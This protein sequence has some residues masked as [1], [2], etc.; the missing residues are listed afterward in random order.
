MSNGWQVPWLPR[1]MTK[2]V[3]FLLIFTSAAFLVQLALDGLTGGDY[4]RLLGLSVL[5]VR[6]GFLWQ[7]VTYLFVHG[8]FW[9]LFLNML[10]LYF[11]GPET[12]RAMGST[13][14]LILYLVS[15]ILGGVGWLLFSD[16]PRV[17]CVGASGALFGV[18]G[19]FAALFPD[20]PMTVLVFYVLPVTMKAWVLAVTLGV[21]ELVF[22]LT[23][24]GGNIAYAAH[25]AGGV[26]GYLYTVGAF[27]GRTLWRSPTGRFGAW[28]QAL[29]RFR[30]RP[31]VSEE[32]L[33]RVLD[34]IA[35][36]GIHSLTRAEKELLD[37]A[38]REKRG[39]S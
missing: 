1:R 4:G 7:P 16:D 26:A 28:I 9:H 20:R 10:G 12:E 3:R 35:S 15:G 17:P 11:L 13:R 24:F 39:L 21:I 8:G 31:G 36:Q 19:A 14:F 18:I 32:K 33:D 6:H 37:R 34:K 27:R 23:S 29:A 25:L 2:V 5:G 22:L 38:S 30:E